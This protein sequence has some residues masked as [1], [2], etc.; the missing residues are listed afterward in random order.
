MFN[1]KNE[2]KDVSWKEVNMNNSNGNEGNINFRSRNKLRLNKVLK[3]ISFITISALSGAITATYVV[4]TRYYELAEKSNTP[5]F[6]E[7]KSVIGNSS[8]PTNSVN[9]VSEEVGPSI[10]GIINSNDAGS[11]G[12]E[13]TISSGIIFKSDGYIVTNYHLI[14][15]ANKVLVRLSNAK[16]GKEIEASLVGFDS[17]S[18]IAIIKVNSHNL[19]TAIF[20]DSSKVRAGDLAIAIGSSLGNEASGSVTAGIVSSANRNLKLQDDANTQGSSYK[21]LQTDASINQINSG[22]ALCNEKGEVI[23]VNSSKIGSQYNSEGMGFAISINQVKDI[24]DQIMKNGKVIKPFV[25]IVGGDIKVRS[26]DNMK[27][28]YVK[29]VVPGSGAAKAGLRPSDIIL[30]LNGQRILSTNDIG[31]IVSSSKIG[32][33]VPCKVNRNGKIVKIQITLTENMSKDD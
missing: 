5:M 33:K 7:K 20:G 18:D 10:V 28:V 29:E 23:G 11:D 24:I 14:N 6:Q 9:K 25:G 19:P 32:D 1:D 13:Q 16:A 17:A 4:N 30:E 22:G 3:F 12:E 2:I 26:Q 21:V 31:S 15:G 27:G 8:V